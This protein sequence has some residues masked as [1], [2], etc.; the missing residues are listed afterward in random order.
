MCGIAG[1]ALTRVA[2]TNLDACCRQAAARLAHRGP[3]DHGQYVDP[4]GGVAL[5]QTRLSIIDLAT[6]HQPLYAQDGALALVANGEIYNHV[7]LRAALEAKGHRFATRSDCETLLHAYAE[8]GDA[9]LDHV[10]GMF[11]FALHDRSRNRLLLARDRLGIKPLFLVRLPDG[12][13]FASEIKALLPLLPQRPAVDAVGLAGY[14]QY[15]FSGGRRTAFAGIERLL[16]GELLVLEDGAITERCRY[17]SPLAVQPFDGIDQDE[18]ERRFDVLMDSVMTRHL[19]ADVPYG[20]FLSGGV[21]SSILLALL[22]RH[23]DAP[24]RSF[25]VGFDAPGMVDELPLA[26]AV[27]ERFG[28]R[29]SEIRPSGDDLLHGLALTVWAA[30]ELMRDYANLP[31][32]M[33]AEHAAR[34]LKVVL[35]GEGGD[36][37]FAGYGRYRPSGIERLLKSWLAPGSGGFRTRGTFRWPATS[38][39]FRAPLRAAC[40]EARRPF[41]EAWRATPREWSDLARRQYSDLV[42]AL[43]DNLLV[44][45]DRMTM[46]HGLEGRVPFLDHRVVEFGLALPDRLKVG[47][48]QGKRFLK[49]WAERLLPQEVLYAPKRGFHVPVSAWLIE[50]RERLARVL[51]RSEAI[52]AWFEPA[53][54]ATLVAGMGK[55][56]VINRQVFAL[57]QFALWHRLF[58]EGEGER[59]PAR[60]DPLDLL[61]GRA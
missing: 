56:A 49:R 53:A 29:H 16:P 54:V 32:C 41:V 26:R 27:A 38:R 8:Y 22:A 19:R 50:R 39:L 25:S 58:I 17:W 61:E 52:G 9:F 5:V 28:S 36:E 18:A 45:L 59:P 35:A 11:A 46:V 15:Q 7:E 43:P 42:T 24:I 3:D 30:D 31:T 40:D 20:L 10:Q 6:G 4:D 21:D 60:I 44:K 55:K 33:L 2:A 1:V 51:A 13:A 23:T 34:E 12:L 47:D 14:L 48:G 37:C 57:L